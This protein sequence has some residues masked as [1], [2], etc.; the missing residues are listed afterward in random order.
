[1]LVFRIALK[2]YSKTLVASGI[3]GRWNGTGRKVLYTADSIALA[4]M[5]NMIRRKGLGFNDEFA[6]MIISFADDLVIEQ[7]ESQHLP[8]GWRNAENYAI[9][10]AIGNKWFDEGLS[11][12]LKVPSAVL[13]EH[14]NFVFNTLHT[15]FSKVQLIDTVPIVPDERIEDILKKYKG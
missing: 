15:D 4:F 12:I 2:K 7:I 5:E 9:C 14:S 6:T 10:Q 1:M 11:P 8:K 13:P 3:E